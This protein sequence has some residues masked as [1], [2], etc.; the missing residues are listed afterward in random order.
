LREWSRSLPLEDREDLLQQAALELLGRDFN[1]LDHVCAELIRRYR[2]RRI[3]LL[4]ARDG[5][6]GDAIHHRVKGISEEPADAGLEMVVLARELLR[7]AVTA[8]P[9][10]RWERLRERSGGYEAQRKRRYRAV[11]FLR[12]A[13]NQ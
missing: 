10:D 7:G 1:D 5:R 13:A 6:S 4:R 9:A 3:D 11:L 8:L 12:A 2:L